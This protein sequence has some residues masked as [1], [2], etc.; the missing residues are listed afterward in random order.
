MM[1]VQGQIF[2]NASEEQEIKFKNQEATAI[3]GSY[4]NYCL[5]IHSTFNYYQENVEKNRRITFN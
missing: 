3:R 1:R 5:L 4:P 2:F